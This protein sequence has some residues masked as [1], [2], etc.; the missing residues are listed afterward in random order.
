MPT[1]LASKRAAVAELDLDVLGAVD[2]VVVGEDV[3]VGAD[4]HARAEA[5]FA[6]R[7][8]L[9]PALP[10]LVAEELPEQ[11]VVRQLRAGHPDA[12][13]GLDGHDRR[14]DCSTSGAYESAGAPIVRAIAAA[15]AA[16]AAAGRPARAGPMAERSSRPA[17]PS[18]SARRP[19]TRLQAEPR[20][21][22]VW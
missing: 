17:I 20:A 10:E 3:A 14:R 13:F 18:A 5:A 11:R 15:G 9:A 4:D 1:T 6:A 8:R 12:A 7:L 22:S 16:T 2:D 21:G 19:T